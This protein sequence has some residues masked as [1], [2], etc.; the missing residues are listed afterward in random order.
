M[1]SAIAVCLIRFAKP[2]LNKGNK[3][4]RQFLRLRTIC[5][6][7][8]LGA[9]GG[10]EHQQPHDT[11]AGH[12]HSVPGNRCRSVELLDNL[13]ETRRCTCMQAL[14]VGYVQYTF[15]SYSAAWLIA[16]TSAQL[17]Y[18]RAAVIATSTAS[19]SGR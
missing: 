16:G 10:A 9:L 6:D 13:D 18:L 12:N 17:R 7:L 3:R 2:A 4:L 19:F 14:F 1:I 11:V 8:D 15:D 5:L